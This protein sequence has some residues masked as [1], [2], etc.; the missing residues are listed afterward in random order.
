MRAGYSFYFSILCE[1]NQFVETENFQT[2][3]VTLHFQ[4][5]IDFEKPCLFAIFSLSGCYF[6]IADISFIMYR[7]NQ[8]GKFTRKQACKSVI[9]YR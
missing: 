5:E 3:F 7:R 8:H 4:I 1:E 2:Y 6:L 9:K